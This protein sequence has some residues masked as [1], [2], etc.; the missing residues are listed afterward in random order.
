MSKISFLIITLVLVALQVSVRVMEQTIS[1]YSAHI[2]VDRYYL[3]L[4]KLYLRNS[5]NE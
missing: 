1:D 5:A 4:L 2:Y 3:I